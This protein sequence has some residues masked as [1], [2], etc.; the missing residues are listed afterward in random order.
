MS[1]D[2]FTTPA[3]EV[4][5]VAAELRETKEA[6][7][8]LSGNLTRIETRLKR[9]FPEA[10]SKVRGSAKERTSAGE[11][12]TTLTS[13]AAKAL[14]EELVEE[15]RKSGFESARE[16]LAGFS[17]PDLAF[18]RRELGASLGKKKPSAKVLI[19]AILGRIRES[20]MLS[21]HTNRQE[22]LDKSEPVDGTKKRSEGEPERQ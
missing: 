14:Y 6:L 20:V 4:N 15:A 2:L 13:D 17:V 3:E 19:D 10:F 18:L 21:K 16:R 22:L 11:A 12:L 8:E 5:R 1:N 9:A 7:R